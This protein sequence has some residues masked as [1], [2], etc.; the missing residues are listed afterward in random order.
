MRA[1]K[2]TWN[3]PLLA[4]THIYACQ[5]LQHDWQCSAQAVET[6]GNSRPAGERLDVS[7]WAQCSSADCAPLPD[8]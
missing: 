8:M 1:D 6:V 3:N 4:Q 5:P 7:L 2:Q